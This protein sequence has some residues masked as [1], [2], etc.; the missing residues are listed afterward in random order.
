MKSTKGDIE[1]G[2]A[3]HHTFVGSCR[4]I[5]LG[6]N[7]KRVVEKPLAYLKSGDIDS[8]ETHNS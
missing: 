5:F 8:I 1:N 7:T 2:R 6:G 4:N 3:R